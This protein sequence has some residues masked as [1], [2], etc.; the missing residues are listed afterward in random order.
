MSSLVVSIN[1]LRNMLP[2]MT[3]WNTG[4]SQGAS[5]NNNGHMLRLNP[6]HGVVQ[7]SQSRNDVCFNL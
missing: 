6:D 2:V 7:F 5:V 3:S 1:L 4:H